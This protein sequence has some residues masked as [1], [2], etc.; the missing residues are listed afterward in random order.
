MAHSCIIKDTDTHHFVVDPITRALTTESKK[1]V[2]MKGDLNSE[3]FTFELPRK[4]EDHDMSE[5]N[6]V[7][8]HF[9]NINSSTRETNAGI[10]P[11][12]DFGVDA[13]NDQ[14][15][16][17]SWLLSDAVTRHAGSLSFVL[18]LACINEETSV[19]T[20]R[21]STAIFSGIN[22]LDGI[23]NTEYAVSEYIDVLQQWLRTLESAAEDVVAITDDGAILNL[24]TRMEGLE[25][26]NTTHSTQIAELIASDVAINERID[27]I[28]NSSTIQAIN[29]EIT[30]LKAADQALSQRI[31][32]I[33]Q[34]TAITNINT[35]I[36]NLKS[37]D[38]TLGNRITALENA[39]GGSDQSEA[40][41]DITTDIDNLEAK[42]TELEGRIDTIAELNSEFSNRLDALENV[43]SIICTTQSTPP[44][45]GT[46]VLLDSEEG[47]KAFTVYG[48]TSSTG[49]LTNSYAVTATIDVGFG[50]T[51][52]ITITP[53][54][55]DEVSGVD[56]GSVVAEACTTS[57]TVSY[58]SE[59]GTATYTMYGSSN[60]IYVFGKISAPYKSYRYERV[61]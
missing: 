51:G 2:L 48:K 54:D 14:I 19:A 26:A 30:S 22:V 31:D 45:A 7:E 15:V 49:T 27:G 41:E 21:W 1:A 57:S 34:S 61:K 18:R 59:A 24:T 53:L 42:D 28:D 50:L 17:C 23:C 46:W 29:S 33:D 16:T 35:E 4:I 44:T 10:C 56:T 5:C 58:D 39:S 32:N 60:G 20:Y 52:D 9:I 38:T 55:P 40:I 47:T 11:V 3:R 13:T 8:V 36:A 12:D 43:G 6:Q 25:S 37:T